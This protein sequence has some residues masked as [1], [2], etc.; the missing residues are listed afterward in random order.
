MELLRTFAVC[1]VY[2]RA[3]GIGKWWCVERLEI[4]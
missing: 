1:G 2:Q 4:L 3:G